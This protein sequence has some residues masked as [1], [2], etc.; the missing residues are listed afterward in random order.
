M[1]IK[2]FVDETFTPRIPFRSLDGKTLSLVVDT[3]FNGELCLPRKLIKEL[4]FKPV[5]TYEIELA[6]GKCIP[7]SIYL[8]EI[9]W[10]RRRTELLAHETLSPTGLVGTELLRGTFFE[11][12]MDDGLVMIT[13]K[14]ARK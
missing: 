4:N 3:G 7:S 9:L 11:L 8:G 1:K 14:P 12:D 2:G 6:D 10:F 5:G 13:E